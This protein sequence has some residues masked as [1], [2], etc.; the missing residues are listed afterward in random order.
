MRIVAH[1]GASGD[2][3]E[4]TLAAFHLAWEQGADAIETDLRLTADGAI[5]AFHDDTLQRIAADPRRVDTLTL[6]ELQS[7]DAG[8]W[9]HPC[10]AAERIPTLDTVA[11]TV[12]PDKSLVLELKGTPDLAEA[13]AAHFLASPPI[14][15]QRVTFLAFNQETI[16]RIKHLLPAA[17][18]LW[19]F[20]RYTAHRLR[21]KAGLGRW[22]T[23]HIASSSLDGVDLRLHP[24]L[25]P[26]LLAPL[27][28][29]G[30]TVFVYTVNAPADAIHCA[31]LGITALTT[32]HPAQIREHL[33]LIPGSFHQS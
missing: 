22:L 26:D 33:R 11:A 32:D 29:S 12:P 10:F 31:N 20:D 9:R 14:P 4:N 6:E 23:E 7:F 16:R 13:V 5:V 2:A 30:K 17:P 3:P 19:L 27:Q 1:R 21:G 8:S 28:K 24:W 15:P 25:H 18:A